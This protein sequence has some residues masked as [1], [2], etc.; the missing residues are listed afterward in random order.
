MYWHPT[1]P[2]FAPMQRYAV[3]CCSRYDRLL[4]Q[5]SPNRSYIC[6]FIYCTILYQIYPNLALP[7]QLISA[8]CLCHLCRWTVP[9]NWT[10]AMQRFISLVDWI[11]RRR[12]QRTAQQMPSPCPPRTAPVG[13]LLVSW[14]TVCK[15]PLSLKSVFH[16]A[17]KTYLYFSM[18][19]SCLDCMKW[20]LG[21]FQHSLT[22]R[23]RFML[24]TG[25]KVPRGSKF[26]HLPRLPATA[27]QRTPIRRIR[28]TK[29][30][31]SLEV[32][33]QG[34][35]KQCF[36]A[37][38]KKQL[39]PSWRRDLTLPKM[40]FW[41]LVSMSRLMRVPCSKDFAVDVGAGWKEFIKS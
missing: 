7:M 34:R 35:W 41:E 6:S 28:F 2:A 11:L 18:S 21:I 31:G 25:P 23:L 13:D 4:L 24:P 5:H 36:M 22:G 40:D 33:N 30:F 12:Q 9:I 27:Y 38:Q 39:S 16:G 20:I 32:L 15:I 29:H 17:C 19:Q 1:K 37:H 26:L 10:H 8:I 3:M 14:L